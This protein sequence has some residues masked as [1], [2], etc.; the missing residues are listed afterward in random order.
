V[1]EVGHWV[2]LYHIWGEDYC[3]DDKVDDTPKQGFIHSGLSKL[4]QGLHVATVQQ[5]I[6]I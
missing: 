5:V 2:N 6:C 3:G 4:A 1:H